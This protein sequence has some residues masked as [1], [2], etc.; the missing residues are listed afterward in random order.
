MGELGRKWAYFSEL[1][2]ASP[3]AS[4]AVIGTS[5]PPALLGI[6]PIF[7]SNR[8]GDQREVSKLSAPALST[9]HD[10]RTVLERALARSV[11]ADA[12]KRFYPVALPM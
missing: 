2:A 4:I 6:L 12:D 7:S 1:F 8:G 9:E 3:I 11:K 10:C 5:K